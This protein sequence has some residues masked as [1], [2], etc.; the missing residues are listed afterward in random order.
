M[1]QSIDDPQIESEPRL[2]RARFKKLL[3]IAALIGLFAIAIIYFTTTPKTQSAA[4]PDIGAAETASYQQAIGEPRAAMRRARL[5]DFLATYI[6]SPYRNAAEAQL[7]VINRHESES[8]R[9]LT[10][11]V[12]DLTV[13]VYDKHRALDAFERDWDSA[14]LGG[15]EADIA[16][17]R[18]ELSGERIN[19]V[20][21]DRSLKEGPSPIPDT[22]NDN[23][24]AGAPRAAPIAPR[25]VYIPPPAPEP[26]ITLDIVAPKVRRN[27]EPSYPSSAIRRDV[28]A[29]VTLKLNIDEKGRVA[30]AELVSVDAPRYA[31]S[32]V[33]AAERAALRTRY[34]PKTIDGDPVAA[35]GV[36]KRYRFQIDN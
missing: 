3:G 12:Y 2:G 5:Q 7:D 23:E 6:Q 34:Y 29:L 10:A 33:K 25:Q 19:T 36:L 24:L 11:Q 13:N 26:V 9:A 15:R 35:S 8:W 18:A 28:E 14:L 31:D 1:Y 27:I 21:P 20:L 4:D 22:F 32:F 17:L 30:M 16:A